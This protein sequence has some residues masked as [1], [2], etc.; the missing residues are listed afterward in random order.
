MF[1]GIGAPL[2]PVDIQWNQGPLSP[3]AERWARLPLLG[4][5]NRNAPSP[6]QPHVASCTAQAGSPPPALHV[7]PQARRGGRPVLTFA[8]LPVRLQRESHRATAAHAGGRVLARP[9]TAS[10]VHCTRL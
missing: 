3:T 8:R 2:K 7:P 10:I 4:L 1:F 6:L 9:V 5:F